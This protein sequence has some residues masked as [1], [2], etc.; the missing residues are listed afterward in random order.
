MVSVN[1]SARQ[2]LLWSVVVWLVLNNWLVVFRP[3]TS[4]AYQIRERQMD[5]DLDYNLILGSHSNEVCFISR[6]Y[7]QDESYV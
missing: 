7:I 6:M 3:D 1:I 5:T 4:C 2:L